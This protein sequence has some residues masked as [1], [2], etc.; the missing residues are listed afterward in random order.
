MKK[1][2]VFGLTNCYNNN[3]YYSHR[4]GIH[5][6]W[7]KQLVADG[8]A[9]GCGN[10]SHLSTDLK[11]FLVLGR[12]PISSGDHNE[13]S[14]KKQRRISYYF[15]HGVACRTLWNPPLASQRRKSAGARF[16]GK[17]LRPQWGMDVDRWPFPA[18]GCPPGQTGIGAERG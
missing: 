6:A 17:G 8:I 15:S 10:G 4:F 1:I 5:R 11:T 3:R 12:K 14:E 13:F 18:P 7:I 2:V 9:T 16:N